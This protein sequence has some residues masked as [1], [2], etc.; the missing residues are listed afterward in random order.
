MI[1][2]SLVLAAAQV[3][4]LPHAGP[5]FD[6]TAA[7][8]AVEQAV[9][10]DAELSRLDNAMAAEYTLALRK[11]SRPARAALVRDQRWF[12]ATNQ[13]WYANRERWSDFPDL[14]LRF[15]T[16][17]EFLGSVQAARSGWRVDG[18]TWLEM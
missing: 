1:L 15:R 18:A 17:I 10:Y 13:E 3:A 16:R 9:C 4:T 12:L 5:S 6:C 7:R 14:A 8:A 11:L 2:Q